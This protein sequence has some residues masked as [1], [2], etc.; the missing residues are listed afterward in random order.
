MASILCHHKMNQ[1]NAPNRVNQT[2]MAAPKVPANP[3]APK[4]LADL[5]AREKT[6]GDPI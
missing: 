3:M 5:V 4:G 6:V 1:M 2:R